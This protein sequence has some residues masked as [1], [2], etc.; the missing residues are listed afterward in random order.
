MSDPITPQDII[1]AI[2]ATP[3]PYEVVVPD[4][5]WQDHIWRCNERNKPVPF[6]VAGRGWVRVRL[7]F[8]EL[9][10][11]FSDAGHYSTGYDPDEFG[12]LMESAITTVAA[13]RSA[14]SNIEDMV[15]QWSR[16]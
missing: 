3:T 8:D 2:T 14:Y 15:M 7:T 6:E 16:R 5:F 12:A 10:D 11:L 9:C 13:V 4:L 1:D